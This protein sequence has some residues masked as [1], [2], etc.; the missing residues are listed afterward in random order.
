[1]LAVGDPVGMGLV[2]SLGRPGGKITGLSF[3]S[4]EL[5]SKQAQ[6][7]RDML[8]SARRIAVRW[9]APNMQA[10][11]EAEA[12][13]AAAQTLGMR[14]E[15]FAFA[16]DQELTRILERATAAELPVEQASTFERIVNLSVRGVVPMGKRQ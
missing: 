13:V 12:A 11:A 1:M 10:R 8:P 15:R 4:T 5:A 6:L 14:S 7:L 9:R 2:L 3:P 16:S